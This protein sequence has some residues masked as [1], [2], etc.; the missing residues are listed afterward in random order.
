MYCKIAVE[1]GGKIEC[2]GKAPVVEGFE[3]GFF[4][5]PTIITGL[6][7]KSRVQQEEITHS[8]VTQL[9][10]RQDDGATF[11][12]W[13]PSVEQKT[14]KKQKQKNKNRKTKSFRRRN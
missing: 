4:F 14:K 13:N 12:P 8:T 6:G 1:E 10:R 3:K 9:L 7:N 11:L 5:E 2:G